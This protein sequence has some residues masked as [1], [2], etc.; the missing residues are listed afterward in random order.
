MDL[1][2]AGA[3]GKLSDDPISTDFNFENGYYEG[4]LNEAQVM[5]VANQWLKA[6]KDAMTIKQGGVL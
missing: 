1:H 2:Q 5:A 4:Y 6:F 3:D